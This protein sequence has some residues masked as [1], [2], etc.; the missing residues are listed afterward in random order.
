MLKKELGL[1]GVFSIASGAMI[2]SGLFILP[3]LAFA[4]AG[5]AVIIAYFFAGV[6]MIPSLLANAELATAMPKSGGSYFFVERSLGPLMGTICKLAF[7]RAESDVCPYRHRSFGG[8]VFSRLRRTDS[9]THRRGSLY[10]F[11]NPQYGQ[12]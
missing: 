1:V 2:S 7:H 5:P 10:F 11:R 8:G 3:G 4:K 12:R 9:E 6:M